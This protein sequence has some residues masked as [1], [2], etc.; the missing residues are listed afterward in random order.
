MFIPSKAGINDLN[1]SVII[2]QWFKKWQRFL[3]KIT[4]F[5]LKHE[6]KRENFQNV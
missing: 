6:K 2:S 4:F 3:T 1:K 5:T